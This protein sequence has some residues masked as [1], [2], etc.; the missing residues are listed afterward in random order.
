M[1][2]TWNRFPFGMLNGWLKQLPTLFARLIT[3]LAVIAVGFLSTR[4][5]ARA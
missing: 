5:G 4:A 3:A 2:R 1:A